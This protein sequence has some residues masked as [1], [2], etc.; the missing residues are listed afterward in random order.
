VGR[1]VEKIER[2]PAAKVEEILQTHVDRIDSEAARRVEPALRKRV[3]VRELTARNECAAVVEFVDQDRDLVGVR[4]TQRRIEAAAL[5]ARSRPLRSRRAAQVFVAIRKDEDR[6][7]VRQLRR[8][9]AGLEHR[10]SV[11]AG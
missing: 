8:D 2:V 9:P 3:P 6:S 10:A 4:R 11:C 1:E 7:P 5:R